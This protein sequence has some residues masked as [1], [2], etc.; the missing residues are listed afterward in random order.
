MENGTGE[1]F[2]LFQVKRN[3][4][5]LFKQFLTLLEDNQEDHEMMVEKLK[6][7]IPPQYHHIIDAANYFDEKKF[8]YLRKK[9]LDAGNNSTRELENTISLF[10]IILKKQ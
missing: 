6:A 10:H 9:T 1:Q 7:G 2:L 4:V 5:A 8:D 3:V